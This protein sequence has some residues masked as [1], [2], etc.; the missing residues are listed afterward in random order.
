MNFVRRTIVALAAILALTI[1]LL[2][3]ATANAS[4]QASNSGRR[5]AYAISLSAMQDAGVTYSSALCQAWRSP[6]MFGTSR[7]SMVNR[8]ANNVSTSSLMS[9]SD[10]KWG[11]KKAFKTVCT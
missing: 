8:I 10:L 3:P 4:T 9:R 6:W 11:V 5:L 1:T 2:V 7:T